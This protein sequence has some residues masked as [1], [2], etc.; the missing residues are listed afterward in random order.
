MVTFGGG[1]PGSVSTVDRIDY[2]NDTATASVKGPL[3]LARN[4]GAATG[5]ISFGYFGGGFPGPLS[6]VDRID[7]SNDTATASPKG[8]LS[9]ARFYSSSNR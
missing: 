8:P 5:N 3:S 6:T 1:N 4:R 9:L 2:S 7:Y